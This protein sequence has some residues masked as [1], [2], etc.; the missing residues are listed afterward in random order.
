MM[1]LSLLLLSM[2]IWRYTYIIF[3][4]IS[5]LV[6]LSPRPGHMISWVCKVLLTNCCHLC[7]I[8]TAI[9]VMIGVPSSPPSGESEAENKKLTQTQV[10]SQSTFRHLGDSELRLF[11]IHLAD[12]RSSTA[13]VMPPGN[14]FPFTCWISERWDLVAEDKSDINTWLVVKV[15]CWL[16]WFPMNLLIEVGHLIKDDSGVNLRYYGPT[17]QVSNQIAHTETP[18]N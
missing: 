15:D 1:P 12:L 8:C 7:C 5:L 2:F 14:K 16:R 6:L 13:P 4:I 17:L 3:V 9:T 11:Q 10:P 18:Y